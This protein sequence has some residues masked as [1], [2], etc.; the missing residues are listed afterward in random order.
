MRQGLEA[1][2][3]GRRQASRQEAGLEAGG[4]P[5]GRR[6]ASRQEAGL[7][8][9]GRP[10]GRRQASRQEAGLEAMES[11]IDAIE[12]GAKQRLG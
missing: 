7:E 6:Q 4:R 5:R 12:S 3:R 8:A 9:G 2:P 1:G 10:R 11:A